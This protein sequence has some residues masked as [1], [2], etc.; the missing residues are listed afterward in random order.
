MMMS[1]L[2]A[3]ALRLTPANESSTPRLIDVDKK[4]A[5]RIGR[6]TQTHGGDGKTRIQGFGCSWRRL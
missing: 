3:V 6:Y 2:L 4:I 5:E 1:A